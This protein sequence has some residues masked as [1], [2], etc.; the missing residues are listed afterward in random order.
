[1]VDFFSY[2]LEPKGKNLWY[3]EDLDYLLVTSVQPNPYPFS[4]YHIRFVINTMERTADELPVSLKLLF[5]QVQSRD[6]PYT[7]IVINN[8]DFRTRM[9]VRGSTT[10]KDYWN[11]FYV[12]THERSSMVVNKQLLFLP[13]ELD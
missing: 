11:Y 2:Q 8:I 10:D 3:L 7:Q 1:M 9:L 6:T 13:E 4:N 5:I 12:P